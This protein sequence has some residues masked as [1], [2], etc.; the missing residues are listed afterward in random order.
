MPEDKP[1]GVAYFQ[2]PDFL[3]RKGQEQ[4]RMIRRAASNVGADA[5]EMLSLVAERSPLE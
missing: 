5:D 1:L 3:N 4:E 2:S